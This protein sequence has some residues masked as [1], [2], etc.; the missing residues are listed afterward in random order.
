MFVGK[1]MFP[2]S[3]SC[4][5]LNPFSKANDEVGCLLEIIR[6]GFRLYFKTDTLNN[7]KLLNDRIFHLDNQKQKETLKNL[8]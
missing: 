8:Q 1:A 4:E 5:R 7:L 3:S 2:P 6:V